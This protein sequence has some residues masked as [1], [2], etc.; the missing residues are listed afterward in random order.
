MTAVSGLLNS[1]YDDLAGLQAEAKVNG[2]EPKF[3][4]CISSGRRYVG[5]CVCV[6][7]MWVTVP[8]S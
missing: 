3:L 7:S 4:G 1:L 2:L 5:V 8:S 6:W